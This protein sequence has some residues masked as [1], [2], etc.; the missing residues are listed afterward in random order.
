M[1]LIQ[2]FGQSI[3][4]TGVKI[5]NT[6]RLFL[7]CVSLKPL[8]G[9][10]G[11]SLGIVSA[12]PAFAI[13][14]PELVIGSVSSLSQLFAVGF[15]MVSGFAAAFGAKLGL[16]KREGVAHNAFLLNSVVFLVLI[17]TVSIGYIIYQSSQITLEKETRLRQTLMRPAQFD[18]TKTQDENL[19]ETSFSTQ[20]ISKLGISTEKAAE[21]LSS[22]NRSKETLFIDVRENAEHRMGTLP[23]AQHIRFPDI[24]RGDLNLGNK[25]LVL[26]CHNG[27]RSSETCARLAAR[28][29]DCSFIAGG[30]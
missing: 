29:I 23:G 25:K 9:I 28:G 19:K 8:L 22:K 4:V 18:G 30:A 26:L 7:Q 21:L 10:G 16:K 12:H 20:S 14:S 24:Q 6:I 5:M 11:V 15:A 27:N 13:P 2:P 1:D 3:R 17:S